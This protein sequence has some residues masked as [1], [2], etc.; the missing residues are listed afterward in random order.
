M[1]NSI[2]IS[3]N[4]VE[5][6]VQNIFNNL[7]NNDNETNTYNISSVDRILFNNFVYNTFITI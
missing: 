2:D 1:S 3:N 4:N 7:I 5:I 6:F